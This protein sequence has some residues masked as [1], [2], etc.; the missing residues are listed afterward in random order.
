MRNLAIH[1][2]RHRGPHGEVVTVRRETIEGSHQAIE[3]ALVAKGVPRAAPSLILPKQKLSGRWAT[4][5]CSG[6][7]AACCSRRSALELPVSSK[8]LEV[9]AG[10][11]AAV[12]QHDHGGGSTRAHLHRAGGGRRR[13]AGGG[14][15][16][17]RGRHALA[18]APR[19]R[20]RLPRRDRARGRL[21]ADRLARG[22]ASRAPP[23]RARPNG[24]RARRT[25]AIASRRAA[26]MSSA[27]SRRA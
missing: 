1:T 22:A 9:A 27:V 8:A 26:R 24:S 14:A 3:K 20:D 17:R 16:G 21:R 18:A 2:E 15:A 23:H 25:S 19:A 4:C 11:A 7:T 12:L 13:V 10:K 6:R 5:S